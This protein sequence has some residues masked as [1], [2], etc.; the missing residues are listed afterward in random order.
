MIP[1]Y[2]FIQDHNFFSYLDTIKQISKGRF[3][4]VSEIVRFI[5]KIFKQ[6]VH[7]NLDKGQLPLFNVDDESK[8]FGHNDSEII[9]FDFENLCWRNVKNS[10]NHYFVTTKKNR[11]CKVSPFGKGMC[12]DIDIFLDFFTFKSLELI[13]K[14]KLFEKTLVFITSGDNQFEFSLMIFKINRDL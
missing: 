2:Q 12:N 4:S 5:P 9:S 14:E 8:I 6:I 13:S 10:N 7:E 3:L 1:K 11:Y